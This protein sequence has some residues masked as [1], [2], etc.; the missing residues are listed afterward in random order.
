MAFLY[1]RPDESFMFGSATGTVEA[2]YD[3][4]WL[5]D[6]RA[7][8]PVRGATGLSLT[9]NA[10]AAR[11]VGLIAV[12]NHNIAGAITVGAHTVPAA[13]LGA[14]GIYLNSFVSV[15]P[16]STSSLALSASGTPSIIGELIAGTRRQLEM[17]LLSE[18]TF[19]MA[20][21]YDWEGEFS[22]LAPYDPGLTSRRL[23]GETILSDTGLA[24]VHAWHASTRRGTRPTLIVPIDTV[25]DPWLVTFTYRWT[26]VIFLDAAIIAG[27]PGARSV[28]RVQFEF[29]ELPRYR[30]V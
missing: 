5:V 20:D 16:F 11:T 28:H 4:N 15:T 19:Q 30:W 27:N 3:A 1:V 6:G 2:T 14:D 21:S 12:V 10:L 9:A 22:S 29:V 13:T 26:P 18:P 8:R 7:G 24:D 17:Q 25:N 23:I